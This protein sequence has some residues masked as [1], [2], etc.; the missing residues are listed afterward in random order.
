MVGKFHVVLVGGKETFQAD[1]YEYNP[2]YQLFAF[3]INQEDG[4][5]V[6][7]KEIPREHVYCIESTIDTEDKGSDL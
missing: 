3:Y 5:H 7:K 2:G 6:R 4:R 1:N